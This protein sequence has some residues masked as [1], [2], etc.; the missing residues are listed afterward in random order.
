LNGLD[1]YFRP[2]A[3]SNQTA[4]VIASETTG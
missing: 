3:I 4:V 2:A 1:I